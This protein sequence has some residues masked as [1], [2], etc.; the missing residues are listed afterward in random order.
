MSANKVHPSRPALRTHRRARSPLA[1]AVVFGVIVVGVLVLASSLLVS[2]FSRPKL[3]P[4]AGT[5]I[6]IAADM[7]GF[8]MEVVRVKVG[9][10]V[11][12]R[13]TSLD[14]SHHTDG[15]GQHQWAVDELGLDLVTG[16]ESSNI[17][18]F[19]PNKPGSYTFYCDICCGGRANPTMQG[20]LIVEA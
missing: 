19:T 9:E 15:G 10:P 17:L 12:I 18:T 8:D 3:A 5:V 2:A 11:T 14:N 13:L 20:T 16:P 6:D 1:G 7:S 4:L